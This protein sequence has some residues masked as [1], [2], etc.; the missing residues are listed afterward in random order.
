MNNTLFIYFL[1]L[2]F[3]GMGQRLILVNETD[4]PINFSICR[5]KKMFCDPIIVK[6]HS[7]VEIPI[8]IFYR[9]EINS[10]DYDVKEFIIWQ[11]NT[12]VIQRFFPYMA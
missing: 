6:P 12:V 4:E 5:E 10:D 3:L 11:P 1:F 8:E 2:P 7:Q 9:Y